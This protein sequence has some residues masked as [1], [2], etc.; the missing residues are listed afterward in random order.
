MIVGFMLKL[1]TFSKKPPPRPAPPRNP[2]GNLEI[3]RILRTTSHL[4][5][6]VATSCRISFAWLKDGCR[7]SCCAVK[8]SRALLFHTGTYNHLLELPAKIVPH[9]SDDDRLLSGTVQKHTVYTGRKHKKIH[10]H[11]H[12]TPDDCDTSALLGLVPVFLHFSS[13]N[14]KPVC[15][16]VEWHFAPRV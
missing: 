2:P 11:T 8:G 15:L 12:N 4:A 6:N 13:E 10:T 5:L 14:L 1:I 16:K 9:F 7:S 3:C